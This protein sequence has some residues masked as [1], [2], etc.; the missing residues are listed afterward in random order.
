[1]KVTLYT[2]DCPKCMVLEKKLTAKNIE[3]STVEDVNLMISKGFDTMPMLEIDD[4]VMDF[5]AANTWINE[6]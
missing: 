4:K 1:M 2:T 5:K 6:Q 3:Y